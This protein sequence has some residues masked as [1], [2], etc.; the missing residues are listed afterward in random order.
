MNTKKELILFMPFIGGGGVEK[1]LFIL[2]N[3]L[4][5]KFK[6]I[7]I[8]T[9]SINKK[10]KFD[11]RIKFLTTSK[12][13]PEYLNIRFKYLISL[14]VLF[15][16]LLNN[17][18]VVVFSFQANI[19]CILVCKVFKI[20]IIV[21]SNSS[22]SGWYHN[23]IKK[24]LYKKIISL[25]D[26]II[27]NSYDFKKEMESRF[28]IKAKCIY[29]PLNKKE[30][31]KK[32]KKIINDKFYNKGFK[33]INIGRLTEQKDQITILKAINII[34]NKIKIRL[35][36]LGNGILKKKLLNYIAENN[37]HK[38]VKLYKFKENPYPYI[39][40]SNL[41]IL[42]SKYEGLPNVL[43]EA[44]T[45]KKPIISSKCPTGPTEILDNG[46]GGLLFK[47]GDHKELAKKILFAY[48]NKT[49]LSKK[50]SYTY[51]NLY[52]YDFKKNIDNYV[53]VLK[54]Y[55]IFK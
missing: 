54:P 25:A 9:G 45:L 13:V 3:Y 31:V 20:K 51:N 24:Y 23:F 38:I 1:N 46:K 15:K 4:S 29:N 55:L 10:K 8:C 16:Y 39:L 12:K 50:I 14:F 26:K 49:K 5:K 17:K 11:K 48:K 2:S 18:D 35:V 36:I 6:K 43:L 22:P 52:K 27:V 37:L 33:I 47:I 21:R 28:Q 19:Y 34:K 42:S 7:T 40:R 44:A 53:D 30:I 41:F 32:S